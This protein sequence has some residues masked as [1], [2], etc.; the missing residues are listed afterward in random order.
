MKGL[1][2]ST[3]R[4]LSPSW[5]QYDRSITKEDITLK[6]DP[7]TNGVHNGSGT[8]AAIKTAFPYANIITTTASA[9]TKMCC[10]HVCRRFELVL[11]SWVIAHHHGIQGRIET[12]V[13]N[14]GGDTHYVAFSLQ[15]TPAVLSCSHSFITK[16]RSTKSRTKK[17]ANN[18]A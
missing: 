1:S 7:L 18:V 12:G 10:Q 5:K 2:V 6:D 9:T 11:V 17:L 13:R 3:S 8:T 4:L 15:S 14:E 16:N